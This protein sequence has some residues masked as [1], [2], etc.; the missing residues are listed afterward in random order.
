MVFSRRRE[1]KTYTHIIRDETCSAGKQQLH[2]DGGGMGHGHAV[3]RYNRND[4]KTKDERTHQQD[5][6]RTLE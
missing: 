5:A 1:E 4:Q 2:K 6:N 3:D